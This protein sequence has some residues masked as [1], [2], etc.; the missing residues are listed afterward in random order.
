MKIFEEIFLYRETLEG[1]KNALKNR[2]MIRTLLLN[3]ACKA[4]QW[5]IL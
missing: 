3:T 5:D 4:V 1:F 2:L